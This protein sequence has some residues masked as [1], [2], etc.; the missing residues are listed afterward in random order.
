MNI[1]GSA[2]MSV[3]SASE[4]VN[5]TSTRTSEADSPSIFDIVL[6]I[7]GGETTGG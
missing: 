5:I 6:P 2:P 4:G 1:Y 7:N 3:F